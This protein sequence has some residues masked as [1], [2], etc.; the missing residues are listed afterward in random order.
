[1]MLFLSMV[2]YLLRS[3]CTKSLIQRSALSPKKLLHLSIKELHDS[4][5]GKM[6]APDQVSAYKKGRHSEVTA[7][8]G[9]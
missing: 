1:M 6:I 5:I 2:R 3:F 8:F 4:H 9:I 7:S